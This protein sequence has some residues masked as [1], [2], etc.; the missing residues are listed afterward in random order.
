MPAGARFCSSCGAPSA[1]APETRKVVTVLFCDWIGST[2]LGEGLDVESLRRVQALFFAETRRA[3]ERHGGTV[4]KFIGDAVMAVFGIPQAHEDDALRAAR[5]A[6]ELREALAAL[7]ERLERELGVVLSVRTGVNTGEVV[8]GEPA[9]GQGFVTGDAV[10]VAKRLEEGASAGEILI[11]ETTRLLVRNAAL[12]EP[13]DGVAAKGKTEPLVAWRLLGVIAG[14]PAFARRLD[15]ALVGREHEVMLLQQAF[16][17]ATAEGAGHLFTVLGPAGVGKSRLVNELLAE[18]GDRA[19]V[20]RGRCL[21]Y[22][23]GITFWPLVDVVREAAQIDRSLSVDEARSRLAGLLAD[24]REAETIADR[25][26]AAVGMSDSSAPAE[27]TFWATRR[28]LEALSRRRPVVLSFDDVQWGEPTFLDLVEYLGDWTRDAP[29]LLICLARPE[30]LDMRRAWGGGRPNA[31]TILLEPLSDDESERLVQN[32]LGSGE[33]AGD[34]KRAIAEAT[35]GNPLFIE[36]TLSM[37]IEDGALR[38]ENGAWRVDDLSAVRVPPTIQALLAARLD[39]LPPDERLVIETAAVMGKLFR[40][41]GLYELTG[42]PELEERLDALVRK[43]LIRPAWE[44]FGEAAFEFRHILIQ[45][46]VYR[47]IPKERRAGI[48]ER[49]AAWL[50]R[51]L[52]A[53]VPEELVGYHLEQ[54]YRTRA[55]LGREHPELGARAAAVLGSA[56]RKALA[57]GD[58]PAAQ[59]LLQRVAALPGP[60]EEERLELLLDLATALR[61]A[62]DLT[63]AEIVVADALD[64]AVAAG[65]RRLEA[66][67]LV[68]RCYLRFFTDPKRWT[69]EALSTAE[70]AIGVLEELDDDVGLTEAWI[71]VVLFHYSRC[72]I[73]EMETALDPALHHATRAGDPRRISL[74]LNAMTRA[75]LVGPTLVDEAIARCEAIAAERAGDRSLEAVTL[76]VRAY[77]EAMRGRFEEARALYGYS[78]E[79]FRDLGQVRLLAAMRTYSGAVELLADDPVAAE[80]ELRT[81]AELLE[82]IHDRGNLATLAP[83]LSRALEAQNRDDEAYE[84]TALSERIASPGDVISQVAWRIARARLRAKKGQAGKAERLASEAAALAGETD[85]VDLH[86]EAL[87]C[88]GEVLSAAGRPDEGATAIGRAIER[89]E[90]KGNTVSAARARSLLASPAVPP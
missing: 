46:A 67:T 71:L 22:G 26:A 35:E 88:L 43:E 63:R 8:A 45:D 1:D 70:S 49:F 73:A 61:E 78:Q 41:A 29:I 6:V 15:A 38:R 60:T 52:G 19:T 37:L 23:E 4:E 58:A 55:E 77:L 57:R 83:L 14:A 2:A 40:Q 62:G 80:R 39:R 85:Y 5:A 17:R 86:G 30:L 65:D 84:Y 24:D 32:L 7:N 75:A 11:G 10:V 54:A 33:L 27:E 34:A 18:V 79:I 42:D 28:L 66:R 51:A 9:A 3:I 82:T 20:L 21:P 50:E 81:G 69:E 87:L 56:G 13:V 47:A 74:L 12:V 90:A 64:A 53:R 59:S 76:G 31:T 48:H 44:R 89:Y 68:E 25:I 36:E 16:E 72:R